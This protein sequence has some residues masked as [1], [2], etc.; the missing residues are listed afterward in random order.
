MYFTTYSVCIWMYHLQKSHFTIQQMG[1]WH[2]GSL[3]PVSKSSAISHQRGPHSSRD[4]NILLSKGPGPEQTSQS[5]CSG[6]Q[7]KNDLEALGPL[8][9]FSKM[10]CGSFIVTD[11]QDVDFVFSII[12]PFLLSIVVTTSRNPCSVYRKRKP[13][14]LFLW[15]CWSTFWQ[16]GPESLWNLDSHLYWFIS[17]SNIC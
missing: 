11:I 8:L 7:H 4:L 12:R 15:C 3:L 9:N 13:K 2:S 5:T 1:C 14:R 10:H 6:R 16:L 17:S